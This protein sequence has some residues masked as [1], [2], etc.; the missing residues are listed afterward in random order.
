MRTTEP[1]GL[2]HSALFYDSRREYVDALTCFIAE[3]LDHGEPVLVAAPGNNLSVLR[4]AVG[5]NVDGL[6]MA[7]MTEAGRNPG[8]ILGGLLGAF[9][10]RYPGRAVRMIGEPIWPGR[11]KT[12]YPACV[13]HEALINMAFDGRDIRILCPYDANRLD[14]GVLDDARVTHRRLWRCGMLR[15]SPTYAPN[16]ALV[17]YNEPLPVGSAWAAY[18]V[19]SL[20][21]LRELRVFATRYAQMVGLSANGIDDLQLICTELATNSVQ[22]GSGICR[23]G[24]WCEDEY[25]VCEARDGGQLSDPLA[26]RRLPPAESVHGR[27]LFVVNAVA[28]LVRTHTDGEGT[29]IRVYLRL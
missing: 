26:G 16:V 25:L 4:A 22:H 3:G 6:T 28:D 19:E 23:L 10:N 29:T 2:V 5:E 27:G 21:D 20:T 11:T 9:A 8:H 1:A 14:A 13:Q 7:D 24:L 18:T 15:D 12:E 17:R